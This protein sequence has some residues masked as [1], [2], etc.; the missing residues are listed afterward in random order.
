MYEAIQRVTKAKFLGVVVDQHLS[1]KDNISM[2][3][4][5]ISKS[6]GIISPIRNTLDIKC[7]KIDLLSSHT[8]LSDILYQC[9][10]LYLSN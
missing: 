7:K 9:L 10:V 3:S 6:C 8:S 5:N 2:V 4:P 1:W